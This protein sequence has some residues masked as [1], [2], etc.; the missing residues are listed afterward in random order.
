MLIAHLTDPHIGL[1]PAELGGRADPVE[2]LRRALVHVRTLDPAPDVL[3]LSGDL[4]ECGREQ[5]Y[6]TIGQL[7]SQ[8]LPHAATGGPRVLAVPGNHDQPLVARRL[9]S[10]LMPQAADAPPDQV[11]MHVE[12]GGLHFIGLD[13]VSPGHA[14][15][16]LGAAQ[17]DWLRGRLQQC[18]GAPV[19][20]F[21][22]HPPLVTG[23]SAM[24][25]CGLLQGR[26][27]LATLVAGH[28]GVQM[29]LAGHMHRPIVGAL[30]GAPVVVA[31]S[32]S[33][34]IDLDLR[35][36]AALACRF[37]P[38]MI[39]LYRWTAADGVACHFSHVLP[40]EG[41]LPI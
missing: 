13:T 28:G 41:P 21:M 26:A 36:G 11:C 6:A 15:G 17:L 5:D 30:G 16:V 18:S 39:G 31:P 9:L 35:P 23:I 2:G 37:E 32:T 10:E 40:F 29:I 19:V 3:L 4:T 1:N 20:I 8:E 38:L 27:E 25:Q 24:D 12:H 7:L 14:H 22:H 34:Q 33:H